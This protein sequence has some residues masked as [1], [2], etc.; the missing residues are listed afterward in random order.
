MRLEP[1][2]PVADCGK[3]L[4]APASGNLKMSRALTSAAVL[5]NT[6]L[7]TV[8]GV[9]CSP[10]GTLDPSG[11]SLHWQRQ[12]ELGCDR[13]WPRVRS[14]CTTSPKDGSTTPR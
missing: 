1:F 3:G 8:S 14:W 7:P 11:K 5:N 9:A 10:L 2:T 4:T 6:Y 13:G 12:L